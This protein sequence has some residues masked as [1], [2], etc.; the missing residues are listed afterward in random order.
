MI[1]PWEMLEPE[2]LTNLIEEFV[3]RDGTDN[4]YDESLA[5]KVERVKSVLKSGELVIVFDQESQTPNL[6]PK[7][8]A[9]L[10]PSE[11]E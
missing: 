4:G 9:N 8:Q 7:D 3:S 1:I 2:T 11:F 5:R 6:L 10:L